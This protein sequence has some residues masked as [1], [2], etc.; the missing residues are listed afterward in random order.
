M[1][2]V[3]VASLNGEWMQ[4]RFGIIPQN[5]NFAIKS[6]YLLNLVDML[7][8]SLRLEETKVKITPQRIE[9]FVCLIS[10]Q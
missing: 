4:R 9:P 7:P 8:A 2:G 1:I 10:A 3:V 6:D 5:V